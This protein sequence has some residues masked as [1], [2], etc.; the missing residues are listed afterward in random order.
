M[1][2]IQETILIT[3]TLI[4]LTS[5]QT[6]IPESIKADT[7]NKTTSQPILAGRTEG[8]DYINFDSNACKTGGYKDPECKRVVIKGKTTG[9]SRVISFYINSR[10]A[11][12]FSGKVDKSVGSSGMKQ[13]MQVSVIADEMDRVVKSKTNIEQSVCEFK[14]LEVH[15]SYPIA[16]GKVETMSFKDGK[17]QGS[18]KD[19]S[20]STFTDNSKQSTSSITTTQT[21]AYDILKSE[22]E[23]CFARYRDQ[24]QR[25]CIPHVIRMN[26]AARTGR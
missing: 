9:K 7:V 14:G 2:L 19:N 4:N 17:I 11:R 8:N 5:C 26:E 12:T 3:L 23:D 20:A 15:C 16:S 13:Q 10:Q 25:A 6:N 22:A 24:D 1:K 21:T 18:I